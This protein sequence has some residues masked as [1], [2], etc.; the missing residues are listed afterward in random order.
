MN[1]SYANTKYIRYDRYVPGHAYHLRFNWQGAGPDH[2]RHNG[3]TQKGVK[4]EKSSLAVA[5]RMARFEPAPDVRQYAVADRPW[6]E[7]KSKVKESIQY[8]P[9]NHCEPRFMAHV[10][11][12]VPTTADLVDAVRQPGQQCDPEPIHGAGMVLVNHRDSS[13]A[14]IHRGFE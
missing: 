10:L 4:S 1:L 13:L 6:K 7:Q 2:C 3:K 8:T 9:G 12:D 14:Q 5:E 11:H